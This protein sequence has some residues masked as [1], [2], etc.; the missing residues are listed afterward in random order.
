MKL[1]WKDIPFGIPKNLRPVMIVNQV[2]AWRASKRK[3]IWSVKVVFLNSMEVQTLT[4]K[5]KLMFRFSLF[6]SSLPSY[7]L[8]N[9][10]YNYD[11]KLWTLL[12]FWFT[13][14]AKR[15]KD[16]TQKVVLQKMASHS[17]NYPLLLRI[18]D[19]VTEKN[20]IHSPATNH[21]FLHQ[22]R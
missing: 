5:I 2:R 16:F 13:R 19:Y 8:W 11:R 14:V 17:P 12:L 6:S 1:K 7:S 21:R 18:I 15:R 9:H 3:A 22:D 10:S 4:K 20:Y